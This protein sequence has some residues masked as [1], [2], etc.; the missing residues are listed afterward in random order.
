MTGYSHVQTGKFLE[1]KVMI[2]MAG[3]EVK[4]KRMDVE[5]VERGRGR[6]RNATESRPVLP[7]STRNAQK[8][9][10]EETNLPLCV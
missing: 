4:E 5:V 2:K 6:T 3:R 9:T 10:P 7:S 8:I 1:G